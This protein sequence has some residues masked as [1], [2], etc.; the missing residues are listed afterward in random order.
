MESLHR[1]NNASCSA[2]GQMLVE[3]LLALGL[4][5]IML[6]ALLI[7]L[8]ASQSGKAQQAQR[9][10]ATT[11]SKEAYDAIRIVRE[12]G[13]AGVS[14]NGTY[15]PEVTGSTWSLVP[16]V[17]TVGGFSR[18]ITIEDAQRDATGAL[19]SSGGIPDPS[20]K[21]AT[22]TISWNTPYPS[23]MSATYYMAR[24]DNTAVTHTSY[25][26]FDDGTTTHTQVTNV[27]GGEVKLAPNTKGQWCQPQLS[28]VTIDLPGTPNA[29]TA[30]E[31][32][33]YVST[34]AQAI[35]SQDSFAHIVVSNTDPPVFSLR[36]KLRGYKTNAVFGESDWGYIA[37]T[38]DTK[39]VVI[40]NL[41]QF[42]DEPN[43]LYHEEGYFNTTTNT[44]GSSSTDADTVFVMNNR[45]YM[46]AGNYL[47]VFN[48]DSKS[49][50]RPKIGNRIQFANSGDTAGEI[51][52]R[53]VDG[54][55][56]IFVAIQGSTPEELK[57][58]NVTNPSDSNQWRV[59][60]Q[61]NIEPNNCSSLESGKAVFVNPAGTRAFISS[62]NDASFKEFFVI[63][64]TNKTNPTLIG[65]LATNP[66]CTNG[67]GYE[68]G[69][70]DP[71]QSVVVSLQE[72]RAI[73]VGL[74]G[75]EYQVLNITNE[76]SPT[77]C[78]GLNYN[79]GLYGVAAVKEADG[80]AYAYIITGD[81]PRKVRMIQGGPDGP[82]LE[83]GTYESSRMDVGSE[84]TFNRFDVT[85]DLPPQT[86]IEYQIAVADPVGGS[87]DTANYVFV[88]PDGTPA[89]TFT[90]SGA[91]PLNNDGAGYENPGQ[92]LKYRAYLSTSD[93]SVTPQLLDI[94]F[95]FSL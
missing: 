38:N 44:G 68:A 74:N 69:G 94:L 30:V 13:W 49:G 82:Y 12:L 36:G 56:Y 76:A 24:T 29:V 78:G 23:Q 1:F 90:G 72:N 77:R 65:G 32:N 2:R 93:F 42:D 39:E 25:D 64:T 19:V 55:T 84:A 85:A 50:S 81:N 9:F 40:I 17:E 34:G 48:L 41:N 21:K 26:D 53:V 37:T 35:P 18:Y 58:L 47:Y 5:A 79:T 3:L 16:G 8:V 28:G 15:H 54:T 20:T 70:M 6:P 66:P 22:I 86:A 91:I 52:G 14:T 27:S 71:E 62:T 10:D 87:C 80:D 11:L 75:E 95:N 45:G 88:G 73:L 33:I 43:K 59:V 60:G 92:C 57:V 51:Y 83:S 89:T 67:G 63:D 7:G 4:S 46:T 61:I 31:G